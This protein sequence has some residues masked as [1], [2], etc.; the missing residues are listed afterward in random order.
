ML[1]VL[2]LGTAVLVCCSGG[3]TVEVAALAAVAAALALVAEAVVLNHCV[4]SAQPSARGSER[5]RRLSHS[6]T[7]LKGRQSST[8]RTHTQRVQAI[9][10]SCTFVFA[11]VVVAQVMILWFAS[12]LLVGHIGLPSA[13][14]WLGFNC[15]ELSARGLALYS[16]SADVVEMFVGLFV[17]FQ[18]LRPI[19]SPL[20]LA[21]WPQEKELFEQQ[22]C[23]E[24]C[25]P[26]LPCACLVLVRPSLWPPW[27]LLRHL[28]H[29]HHWL[30]QA[31]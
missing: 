17:L 24:C 5:I 30:S 21:L 27:C 4:E 23:L 2:A 19:G 29:L 11:E 12:F 9:R 7:T 10:N 6:C 3:G 31:A 15:Q 22:E 1:V 20:P 16:L 28:P 8:C 13:V 25:Q 14:R 18:C 26:C